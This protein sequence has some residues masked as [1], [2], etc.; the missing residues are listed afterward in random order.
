MITEQKL[1]ENIQGFT[2]TSIITPYNKDI[3]LTQED[4]EKLSV[5]CSIFLCNETINKLVEYNPKRMDI[6]EASKVFETK[7]YKDF[8]SLDKKYG[9]K[10][11]NALIMGVIDKFYN[12]D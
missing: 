7:E 12:E 8:T 4:K 9:S 11:F 10:I 3:E 6:N 2:I 5:E 1:P